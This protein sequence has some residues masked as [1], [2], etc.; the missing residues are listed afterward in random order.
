MVMAKAISTLF[1]I[2][3]SHYIRGP[4]GTA[5]TIYEIENN[6]RRHK[7]IGTEIQA[8]LI[9][10]E[11]MDGFPKAELYVPAA[12]DEFV[13]LAYRRHY[14]NEEQILDVDCAIIERCN[15]LIAY[16]NPNLS[17]GMQVEI[18]HALEN[19]IPVY[20]MPN[21]D[22]SSIDGLKFTIALIL[23]YKEH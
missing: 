17:R 1:R 19:G 4:S 10:W 14:I 15:L 11:K 12:H 7:A 22:R 16:D 23:G 13:Q 6:I 3:V 2:Y 5:A 9:D 21:M 18:K 20:N 8:Y